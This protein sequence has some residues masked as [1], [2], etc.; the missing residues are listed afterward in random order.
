MGVYFIQVGVDGPI[1]IGFAR[2]PT[3]RLRA[4][5]SCN[6]EPT[7]LVGLIDGDG[8]LE[9]ILHDRFAKCWLRG[10]WFKPEPELIEF[11]KGLPSVPL[12]P[13]QQEIKKWR[14]GPVG[15]IWFDLSIE[16]DQTA[17]KQLGI[18]AVTLRGRLGASGR[19]KGDGR[20]MST[21]MAQNLGKIGG[22][23]SG[24]S[25]AKGRMPENEAAVIWKKPSDLSVED[26]L[27]RINSVRKY[28]K[29]WTVGTA[30]RHLGKS[31]GTWRRGLK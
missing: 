7:T 2:N 29:K 9:Q 24:R 25:K 13:R 14:E 19:S 16:T 5:Q 28:K 8:A 30:F 6:H 15:R 17:A 21:E 3:M 11:L 10:E 22:A 23:A 12:T 31:G 18:Q 26:R 27:K 4:I 1:K 20:R